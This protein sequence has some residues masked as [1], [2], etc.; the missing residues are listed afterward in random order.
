MFKFSAVP[1]P[2]SQLQLQ[3]YDATQKTKG[4]QYLAQYTHDVMQVQWDAEALMAAGELTPEEVQA[5]VQEAYEQK[6]SED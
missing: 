1:E 2:A 5:M 6:L 3:I 4:G